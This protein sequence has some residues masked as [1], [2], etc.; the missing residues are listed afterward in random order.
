MDGLLSDITDPHRK[1][2]PAE[3]SVVGLAVVS[4][5]GMSGLSYGQFFGFANAY[6]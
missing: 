1:V 3:V 6:R 2:G 4:V 5:A